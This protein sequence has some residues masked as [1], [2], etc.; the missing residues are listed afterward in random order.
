MGGKLG[1]LPVEMRQSGA[2]RGEGYKD[3]EPG[4]VPSWVQSL[5]GG[6]PAKHARNPEGLQPKYQRE[7]AKGVQIGGVGGRC[8]PPLPKSRPGKHQYRQKSQ[9]ILEARTGRNRFPRGIPAESRAEVE[10]EVER[11]PC[12]A[13]FAASRLSERVPRGGGRDA[14]PILATSTSR[15]P[16]SLHPERVLRGGAQCATSIRATPIL[17]APPSRARPGSLL[18]PA[19]PALSPYPVFPRAS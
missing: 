10:P 9:S 5:V 18:A 13:P 12:S 4:T 11:S 6:G 19:A 14:P 17:R 15:A 1:P 3:C 16:P 8:S 7:D 2:P